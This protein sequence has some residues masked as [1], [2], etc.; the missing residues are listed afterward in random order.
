MKNLNGFWVNKKSGTIHHVLQDTDWSGNPKLWAN[1]C[2]LRWDRDYH[3]RGDGV[4]RFLKN[5]DFICRKP[6]NDFYVNVLANVGLKN[7]YSYGRKTNGRV[8]IS[9]DEFFSKIK[10]GVK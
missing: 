2:N 4:Q 1:S 9:K 5:Y 7:D 10:K 6:S 3:F 8:G